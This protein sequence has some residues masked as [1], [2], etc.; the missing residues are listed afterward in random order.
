MGWP[1][2]SGPMF[3]SSRSQPWRVVRRAGCRAAAVLGLACL[4]P[5]A[6]PAAAQSAQPSPAPPPARSAP[7]EPHV[8]ARVLEDDRV[9][10]EELSVRGQPRRLVVQ[11]KLP[12]VQAYEIQPPDPA[13][14]TTAARGGSG[15]RVWR[16]LAF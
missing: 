14:D 7:A 8:Q 12:G 6:G 2:E 16:L 4:M 5:A 9:R 10:I 15:Q 11:P 3:V 1:V 13:R